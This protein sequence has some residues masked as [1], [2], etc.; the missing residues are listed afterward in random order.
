MDGWKT[1]YSDTPVLQRSN[2][3]SIQQSKILIIF[4]FERHAMSLVKAEG[5]VIRSMKMGETSKLVTFFT[6]ELGILKVVAKGSRSSKSRFGAALEMLTVARIVYYD[7]ENRELQFLSQADIAE[8]FPNLPIELE[9]WGLANACGELIVRSQADV[10][11]KPAL[12]PIFLET[13]RAMNDSDADARAC[14]WGFQMKLLGVMGVAPNLRQCQRCGT[15]DI[16]VVHKQYEL[17]YAFDI[18][19]GGVLCGE[20]SRLSTAMT[21][22]G[23]THRLLINFQSLPAKKLSRYK[24]SPFARREI[25]QFFRVYLEHHAEEIGRLASIKFVHEVTGT[26]HARKSTREK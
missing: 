18:A 20:C 14:F 13:L 1:Q 10:E 15:K 11:V 3:P 22:S 4:V 25:E 16:A 17:L 8:H 6:R 19:Q 2:N 9:K 5:I 7:K 24:I 21:I 23:E 26:E 12:Y